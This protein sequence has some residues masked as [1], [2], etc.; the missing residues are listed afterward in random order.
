[1]IKNNGEKLVKIRIIS[2]MGNKVI[3]KLPISFVKK[4]INNNAIDFFNNKDDIIDSQQLLNLCMKA[5][6]YDLIGEIAHI[7]RKNG[8]SIKIIID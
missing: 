7:E 8:D 2:H 1:M 6:D 5:F 4:M 3:I